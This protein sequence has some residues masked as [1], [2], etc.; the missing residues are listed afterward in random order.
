[1]KTVLK[2]LIISLL[3]VIIDVVEE[4]VQELINKS[5]EPTKI[6]QNGTL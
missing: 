4:L 2:R 1:M 3:P 6:N 5:N